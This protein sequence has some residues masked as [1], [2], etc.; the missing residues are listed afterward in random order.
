MDFSMWLRMSYAKEILPGGL[1]LGIG[2]FTR[3]SDP[4]CSFEQS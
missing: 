4:G 3:L 2:G 1:K